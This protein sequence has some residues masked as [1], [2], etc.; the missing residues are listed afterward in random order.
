MLLLIQNVQFCMH[1][2]DVQLTTT[3]L[4][5]SVCHNN[6]VLTVQVDDWEQCY[7]N[8]A[9]ADDIKEQENDLVVS[10]RPRSRQ[11]L[12]FQFKIKRLSCKI[13]IKGQN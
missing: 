11:R 4:A 9:A 8:E 7:E 6:C 12:R 10:V 2:V 1:T 5:C 3:S 13:N